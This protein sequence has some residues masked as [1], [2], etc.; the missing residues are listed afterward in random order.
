MLDYVLKYW[1]DD[2]L[3]QGIDFALS[4]VGETASNDA[5]SLMGFLTNFVDVS[6]W[7]EGITD[8]H[9]QVLLVGFNF[10]FVAV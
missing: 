5:Y 10:Q 1:P 6:F 7:F 4:E 2:G 3:I 8:V 9:A